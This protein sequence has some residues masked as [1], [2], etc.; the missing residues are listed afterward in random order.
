VTW[1]LEEI[2]RRMAPDDLFRVEKEREP[3][4]DAEFMPGRTSALRSSESALLKISCRPM[5][6]VTI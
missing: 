4:S 1:E 2:D 5:R 3:V 6:K